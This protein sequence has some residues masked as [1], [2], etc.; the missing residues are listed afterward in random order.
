MDATITL[1]DVSALK[2]L[3]TYIGRAGT[4]DRASVR[5]VAA[6]GVLAGYVAML[7]PA[8]LLDE[9]P[10]VLGL[11]TIEVS[12]EL[13]C[14][15]VVPIES[16]RERLD[17]AIE[18]A[19]ENEQ[20]A[21]AL[22]ASVNTVTWAGIA[23]PRTGWSNIGEVA[24]A[25]VTSDAEAGIA[26]VA[27]ALPERVG[28]AIVARVRSEVW[29]EPMPHFEHLPAGAAFTAHTLGFVPDADERLRVYEAGPWQRLSSIR[30]HVLVKRRGWSLLT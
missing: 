8:G 22:P 27:E 7:H 2:D 5:L 30:G 3:R 20:A 18:R 10:T 19:G 25:D 1:L 14:D 24:A 16:L 29:S 15:E 4:A 13:R 6:G 11:R 28:E 26:R 17:R 23:P 9:T 12:R 21:F